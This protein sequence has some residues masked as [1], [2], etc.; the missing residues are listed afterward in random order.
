MSHSSVNPRTVSHLAS[1]PLGFSRQE[2]RRIPSPGDLPDPGI[3]HTSPP[4]L[5]G[6]FF[7]TR[8]TRED[9]ISAFSP[10]NNFEYNAQHLNILLGLHPLP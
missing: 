10:C 6:R 3:E 5:V 8:A 9:H 7:T 4:A 2:Y 1:L